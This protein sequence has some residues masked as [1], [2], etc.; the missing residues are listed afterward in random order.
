MA[1]AAMNDGAD[2]LGAAH[3]A[4]RLHVN[5]VGA[6]MG[7]ARR[8]LGPFLHA[9]IARRPT[10]TVVVWASEG[11][12]SSELAAEIEVRTVPRRGHLSRLRWESWTLPGVLRRDSADAILNL[13]NSAPIRPAVPSLLY[14][15]NSRWFDPAW[16]STRPGS[17]RLESA[18]RRALVFVQMRGV[19]RTLVPSHAMAEY[20]GSWRLFPQ[21]S[22][23]KVIPHAVE[24]ARFGAERRSWPP[25]PDRPVRLLSVSHAATHKG[26]DLL[27]ALVRSLVDSGIPCELTLTVARDD[28]PAYVDALVAE[29]DRLR[30]RDRI[31]LS[32]RVA[33][34]E[35]LYRDADLL[36]FPSLTESFGFPVL[37][38]MASRLPVVASRIGSTVELLGSGGFYFEPGDVAGAASAVRR[39]LSLDE[40]EMR[41]RLAEARHRASLLTWEANAEA[42]C[43]EVESCVGAAA[44]HD[45]RLPR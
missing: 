25:P 35:R 34:V 30:V 26:Q 9:L 37:E 3:A 14:Q 10:W 38:A 33:A 22:R 42:V 15:R 2:T 1:E 4:V 20:L 40:G 45:R 31:H 24:V 19:C 18:L 5:A 6:V 7:G 43:R 11:A 21:R 27:A 13:S 16:V 8:H 32:G 44:S 23:V 17:E 39:A 28:S 29:I 41:H 36:V 12:V